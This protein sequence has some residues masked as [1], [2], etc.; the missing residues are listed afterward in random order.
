MRASAQVA[1][2]TALFG[3]PGN[4]DPVD[5]KAPRKRRSACAPALER[6]ATPP[7]GAGVGP[8]AAISVGHRA[9]ASGPAF[10]VGTPRFF[11]IYQFS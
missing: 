1:A 3:L 9:I 4:P 7:A 2:L 11:R 10:G 5:F 8:P 6:F